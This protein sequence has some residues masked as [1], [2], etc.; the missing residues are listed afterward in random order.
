MLG[1]YCCAEKQ[2]GDGRNGEEGCNGGDLHYES[3]CCKH[4]KQVK[5]TKDGGCVDRKCT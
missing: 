4:D 2:E 3:I 5:C 1:L